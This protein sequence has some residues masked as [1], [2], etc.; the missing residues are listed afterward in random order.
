MRRILLVFTLST[1]ISAVYAQ[2]NAEAL[3]GGMDTI[4]NDSVVF[5]PETASAYMTGL[6]NMEN[7]WSPEGDTMRLSLAR[8]VNHFEEPFDSVE[9]RLIRFNYDSI[10]LKNMSIIHND[11]LPLRWLNDSTLIVDTTE[12]EKDPFIVQKTIVKK[13]IDTTSLPFQY[14][15]PSAEKLLQG[16]P[17]EQDSLVMAKDTVTGLQDTTLTSD[18]L[19][20]QKR[21]PDKQK[22]ESLKNRKG[23]MIV[24]LDTIIE[25]FLD[26]LFLQSQNIEIHRLIDDRIVPSFL[27]PDSH[28]AFRFLPDSSKIVVSD[29][30]E[31]IVPE[32]KSPF[33]II[34]SEK[35]PD[36]LRLAVETL[37]AY[38]N[39]RDSILLYFN[40]IQGGK[41]PF[42]L[43][44][45]K[46]ELYRYWVKNYKNDSITIWVGNP[47]KLDITLLLEQDV[48]VN[49]LTKDVLDE[50]PITDLRPVRTLAEV[51][52]LKEIPVYWEYNFS[53]S[54]SVNQTY[55]SNWSKGGESSLSNMLDINGTAIHTN[56]AEKTEW[57][58]NFRLKYGSTITEEYGLRTNT[59]M[60]NLNSQFNKVI[61]EKIDF[62]AL[63]YMKN[64]IARGY[65]YPNDSVVVSKFLNPGTFTIGAG[66]EYKP[67]KKTT[68]NFSVLSYKN[69]FVLDTANIDQ[70]RHGIEKDKRT[71]Q[72]MGGQLLVKN[73]ISILDGLDM[74]NTLR[75][76]TNYLNKPQN[77]DVDWEINLERKIN[78]YFTILLNFHF[79]YDDDI[80]FP[81]YDEKDTPVLLPD[82][83]T[84]KEPKLQFKQF[85][86]LTLSFKF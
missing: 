79:I 48:H 40:D 66:L 75:L 2:E 29:T 6:L 70:T 84:K 35:M 55:L 38:T 74:S 71:R 37:L 49:R 18:D 61:K 10:R 17:Q 24:E 33:Y 83:S 32:G 25:V 76:F 47:S 78:W 26:T 11:T 5:T 62:S 1:I 59:D 63:F 65:K 56:K 12:L 23:I 7:L 72:E 36:S 27:P 39:Q 73:S 15:L 28:K 86:G 42:W 22:L 34:P 68:L 53:S 8:L 82:G 21:E 20:I 46:D 52:P 14:D 9:N 45:G 81:V 77:V 19:Y 41:I 64:Q 54:F 13:A 50:L 51:E 44:S 3:I 85:M 80:R 58:N 30:M 69:T 16:K 4:G 43:T 57:T 31:V 60:F 67:F